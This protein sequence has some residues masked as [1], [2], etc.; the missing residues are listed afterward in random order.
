M[1]EQY[2][3]EMLNSLKAAGINFAAGLPD[4]WLKNVIQTVEKDP[5]FIYV[6]VCN[7]GVGYSICAGA[8]LGGKKPALFMEN[9]GLR[10]AAEPI[11][12]LNFTSGGGGGYHGIGTLII[13]SYRGDMGDTEFWTIPHAITLEPLLNALRIRYLIVRDAK[14]L[15]KSIVRAARAAFTFMSPAAVVISGDLVMED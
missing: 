10:V 11:A 7:E 6:P 15:R 4:S 13:T 12:R 8:W 14:D 1:K 2:L 3:P 5:H 9:S